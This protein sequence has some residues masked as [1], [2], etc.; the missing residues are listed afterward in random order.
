MERTEGLGELD[1][2]DELDGPGELGTDWTS[3]VTRLEGAPLDRA[4]AK[5][6]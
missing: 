5:V 4:G 2:L 6:I 1:E 3:W